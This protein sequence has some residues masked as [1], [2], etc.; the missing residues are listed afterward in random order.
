MSQPVLRFA[1]SPTGPLHIGGVR[2]ALF[3]FLYA[4]QQG[5]KLLLR[6]EDTDQTRYVPGA[7]DYI[8][9]ALAW[10][11]IEF[12]EGPSQGGDRGPYRQSERG[13]AGIYQTYADQLLAQGDAYYAFDTPEDLDQMR[14]ALKAEGSDVQQYNYV[15]RGRMKNS[16]TLSEDEVKARLASG[17]PYVLRM[18][19]PED[20]HIAFQDVVRGEVSFHTLQ[21]DDKVLLKT[22]G[23]PT[24]HLANVVDDHLM[25]ITHVIRGEE[26]LSSTPLHVALYR[27]FGWGDQMPTFVHLPLILNPNGKG[28]M[29]KR[30]GDKLGFS[31]FP[32]QWTAP[33]GQVSSGFRE[34]GYLP[35]ALLNFLALLGWS[36]GDDEEVMDLARLTE[37]FSLERI[38]NS[39]T[40]FDLDKLNWFN[41]LYLREKKQAAELLPLVKQELS[42]RNLALPEDVY[43]TQAIA[44]M[45]ERVAVLS[46]FVTEATYFFEAPTQYDEKMAKKRWK[47]DVGA[48]MLALAEDFQ[49]L[50]SWDAAALE[51]AVTA[52]VEAKEVGKGKVMAPLRLA[53]TGVAGGPG[54]Y[55]IAALLGRA[56]SIARLKRA[57]EI[58]G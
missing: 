55:D 18:K 5:G 10:L 1:P 42:Q 11:G 45:Q 15:T 29:S 49:T 43:L 2:T 3:N 33:D 51:A 46:D 30:Q 25:G 34:D 48:L 21:L 44:L 9:S 41:Q 31:V 28:K 38:G 19:M 32:T 58:L 40:K 35:E 12:D 13:A 6:I 37:R 36:T 23:L 27:A 4:R 56:E 7:E 20:S 22:D 14:E 16:L 50:A 53:L 8:Q 24:Y 47:G 17:E 52:F 54:V 26:W 39:A 57:A